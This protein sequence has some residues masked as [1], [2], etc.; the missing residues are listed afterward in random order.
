MK[1]VVCYLLMKCLV[2]TMVGGWWEFYNEGLGWHHPNPLIRLSFTQNKTRNCGP[3][4]LVQ[5]EIH[6]WYILAQQVEKKKNLNLLK[7]LD[8]TSSLQEMQE[9]GKQIK[10]LLHWHMKSLLNDTMR[11]Q[12]S[13]SRM[14]NIPFRTTDLVSWKKSVSCEKKKGVEKGEIIVKDL[15]RFKAI[16]TTRKH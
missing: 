8:L 12:A 14:W 16:T 4:D 9:K 3:P 2:Q 15:K 7:S 13:K 5:Y 11:K 6:R 10:S 1:R